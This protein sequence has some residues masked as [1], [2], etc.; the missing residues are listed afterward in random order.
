MLRFL[1][2]LA[3]VSICCVAGMTAEDTPPPATHEIAR[4]VQGTFLVWH[5]SPALAADIEMPVFGNSLTLESFTYRVRDRKRRDVLRYARIKLTSGQPLEDIT[6]FYRRALG[7]QVVQETAPNTG[8]VTLASGTKNNVR[9]VSIFPYANYCHIRLERVQHFTIPPR[10][11]TARERQ[12]MRVVQQVERAYLA[13][14]HVAYHMAQHSEI[15]HCAEHEE[16]PPALD[17]TVDFQRPAQLRCTVT[18]AKGMELSLLTQDGNLL[19][20]MPG[21][22]MEK[23]PLTGAGALTAALLPELQDDL[24]ARLMLGDPLISP[25]IDFLDLQPVKGVPANQ[26][27]RVALTFPDKR[28]SLS[29]VIDLPRKTLLRSEI[30][31]TQDDHVERIIR[32]YTDMRVDA[33]VPMH[34]QAIPSPPQPQPSAPAAVAVP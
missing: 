18:S 6:G 25:E 12:V 27:A 16:P 17:W 26:Q 30:L 31:L 2:I 22:A 24:V 21:K 3:L 28:I 23:R 9:L 1:Y 32:V 7:K 29:L 14:P 8:E 11:Y 19:V 33:P 10:V 13:A 5:R 20:S 34:R 4:T 15:L